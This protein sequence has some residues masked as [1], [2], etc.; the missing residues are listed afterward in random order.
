MYEDVSPIPDFL[1]NALDRNS[2]MGDTFL[3]SDPISNFM[4]KGIIMFGLMVS[5]RLRGENFISIELAKLHDFLSFMFPPKLQINST[6]R[7]SVSIS[8]S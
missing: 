5:E 2:G 8:R 4:F 3:S 7:T 6:K 1:S